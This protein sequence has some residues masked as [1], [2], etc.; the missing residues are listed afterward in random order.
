MA[1]IGDKE[2]EAWGWKKH[3]DPFFRPISWPRRMGAWH[4]G[5]YCEWSEMLAKLRAGLPFIFFGNELGS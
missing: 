3:S 1:A 5:R 2:V 4:I